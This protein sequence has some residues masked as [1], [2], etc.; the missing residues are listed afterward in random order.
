MRSV[1]YAALLSSFYVLA[2]SL[3]IVCSGQI[4]LAMSS[5][6]EE[7]ER[8]ETY[9]GIGFV[10]FTAIVLFGLSWWFFDRDVRATRAS[11]RHRQAFVASERVATTGIFTA[12]IAHDFNNLLMVMLGSVEALEQEAL[13]PSCEC[14]IEELDVAIQRGT[15]ICQRLLTA[16]HAQAHE[17]C[18]LDLVTLID[19]AVSL[20]KL[21]HKSKRRQIDFNA[22]KSVMFYGDAA[23][24]HQL[25]INLLL[26]ALDASVTQ[27]TLSLKLAAGMLTLDVDDDGEGVPQELKPKLFDAFFTTKHNGTGLGLVSVRFC[28]EAHQ[29][30]VQV[31]DSSLG[32]ACFR[33][34]LP[35]RAV[36]AD[37]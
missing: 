27:V 12:S 28:A 25:V 7:L 33:V 6:V 32:G 15:Q 10:F 16:T 8:L 14:L 17:V 4:V 31:M 11:E 19:E 24:L 2:A 3:Y 34:T 36:P 22:P 30:Q 1:Q 18:E 9:K 35:V 23:L 13:P 26:N 37:A 5:S 20:I 29:G 21:H